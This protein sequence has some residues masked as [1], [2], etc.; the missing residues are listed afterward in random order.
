MKNAKVTVMVGAL[1]AVLLAGCGGNTASVSDS[2]GF[3]SKVESTETATSSSI[4]AT[5]SSVPEGDASKD[6]SSATD[7]VAR[8]AHERAAAEF[9]GLVMANDAAGVHG[10]LHLAW[11]EGELAGYAQSPYVTDDDVSW[12]LGRS[13]FADWIGAKDAGLVF[14]SEKHG[15][16][17]SDD[18]L[19]WVT[20]QNGPL[21][22]E[23]Y[24]TNIGDGGWRIWPRSEAIR[25]VWHVKVPKGCKLSIRGVDV[26]DSMVKDRDAHTDT[27]R[28]LTPAR[29]LDMTLVCGEF[30]TFTDMHTPKDDS[31]TSEKEQPYVFPVRLAEADEKEMIAE[32]TKL[33]DDIFATEG[34]DG[35]SEAALAQYLSEDAN[36]ALV[37]MLMAELIGES[38]PDSTSYKNWQVSDMDVK[39]FVDTANALRLEGTYKVFG[40]QKRSFVSSWKTVEKKTKNTIYIV[41]EDGQW[42]LLDMANLSNNLFTQRDAFEGD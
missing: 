40:E 35:T 1:V 34:T 36:T 42:K 26:P 32:A 37:P 7:E 18:P 20:A 15:F 10:M 41:K 5:D 25:A 11:S 24:V 28:I 14:Q 3:G 16:S 19:Y 8:P 33:L 4:P 30:G 23:F 39:V 21:R 22:A 13:Q 38:N 27:Y 29:K 2:T 31:Q 17:D 12:W 9:L 6:T